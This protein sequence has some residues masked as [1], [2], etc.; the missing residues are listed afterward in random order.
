MQLG[1]QVLISQ[2]DTIVYEGRRLTRKP[3]VPGGRVRHDRQNYV[4]SVDEL[5]Q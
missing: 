2:A 1:P 4:W 3:R 5:S